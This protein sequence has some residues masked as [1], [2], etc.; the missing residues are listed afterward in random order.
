MLKVEITG[1]GWVNAAGAG[2]GRQAPFR[3]GG[4]GPLPKLS[5]IDVSSRPFPRFGRMDSYS[6]L[7]VSAISYA[8]RDAGLDEWT[9]PRDVAIIASTVYGCLSLD[10]DYYDTV[11]SEGGRF[12]SPNLFAYSLANT[13]LGEAAIHFGLTG[14]SFVLSEPA[15]S[16]LQGLRMAMN[17]IARGDY[18]T[19]IAGVC[20]VGAPPSL[21]ATGS[22]PTGALFFVIQ[23]ETSAPCPSY[24][25]LTLNGA[26]AAFF[27]GARAE[28]LNNLASMCTACIRA[29][30]GDSRDK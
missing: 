9:D 1:V 24:G 2:Y 6:R 12:A 18:V 13:Y 26:G 4:D 22:G 20:D 15:L 27:N 3:T 28:D 23:G 8:L 17:G 30:K 21:V 11:V 14:P 19:A 10:Y 16:G 5:R 25:T 29:K 7:G